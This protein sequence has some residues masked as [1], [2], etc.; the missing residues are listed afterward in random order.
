MLELIFLLIRSKMTSD[1]HNQSTNI[2]KGREWQNM[3]YIKIFAQ[4]YYDEQ[5]YYLA[6]VSMLY[7]TRH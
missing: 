1:C 5:P 4:S 3:S 6:N 2:I 7:H